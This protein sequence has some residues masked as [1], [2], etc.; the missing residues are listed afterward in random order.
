MFCILKLKTIKNKIIS[1]NQNISNLH[2][3]S[4]LITGLHEI[5]L[6]EVVLYTTHCKTSLQLIV[7]VKFIRSIL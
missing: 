1:K 4:N 5:K 6:S 2:R 7:K 3:S